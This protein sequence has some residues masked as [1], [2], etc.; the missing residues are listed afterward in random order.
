MRA[1]NKKFL[2]RVTIIF[3]CAVAVIWLGLP[4][5]APN[6]HLSYLVSV[7]VAAVFLG[8]AGVAAYKLFRGLDLD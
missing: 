1:W 5:A 6:W 8:I 3:S 4:L 7:I 2:L